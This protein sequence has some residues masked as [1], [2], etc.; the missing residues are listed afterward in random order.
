M[1]PAP[2]TSTGPLTWLLYV[3][4]NLTI[5]GSGSNLLT[6]NGGGLSPAVAGLRMMV[7]SNNDLA[8]DAPTTITGV[9]F[10]EGRSVASIAAG[11]GAA[12]GCLFSR[13][14]LTLTD[15]VFSGCEAAGTGDGGASSATNLSTTGGALTMGATLATDFRPN[16]TLSNVRFVGNRTVHGTAGSNFTSAGGG[17][18][19]G[20]GNNL[21]VGA[22]SFSG[23]TFVGNTSE[24]IGG[25]RI[26][27][28]T[29]VAISNTDFISNTATTSSDGGFLINNIS[30]T[31]TI[32][33]SSF[34]G[35]TAALRRGGGQIATVGS[36]LTPA[37]EVITLNDV[38]FIGNVAAGQD[39]GDSAA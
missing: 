14:F 29:S 33:G 21:W 27:G 7:V 9:S 24:T 25:L 37:D 12:G 23:S 20:N 15:V 5:N 31:V 35:N 36:G 34:V 1:E 18:T 4:G 17:A 30:G 38:F 22:I 19:F 16:A 8:V 11:G 39:I 3:A 6:I 13:E 28:A 10:K 2:F 26:T 32:S